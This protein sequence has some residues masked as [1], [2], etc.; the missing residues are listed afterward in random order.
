MSGVT[1]RLTDGGLET[2]LI[3]HQGIGLPL[4]AAFPLVEHEQGRAALRTHWEPYVA[5]ARDHAIPFV[6][7]TPTWR[8]NPDW[9]SQLGYAEGGVGEANRAA[10]QFTTVLAREFEQPTVNGVVGPRGDG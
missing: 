7:D 6:V 5:L 8:A 2:S 10:A 1:L 9:M 3:F 4:F